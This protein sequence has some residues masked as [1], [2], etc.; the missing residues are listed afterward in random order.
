MLGNIATYPVV[1][2]VHKN[3][4]CHTV[5]LDKDASGREAA[6]ALGRATIA[7]YDGAGVF[8]VEMFETFEGQFLVNE[9][10]PRVH[11]SGHWTDLGAETSQFE[12]HI[13]AITGDKLGSTRAK[14]CATMINILRTSD[15]IFRD[16]M[17]STQTLEN[18]LGHVRWYGKAPKPNTDRKIGHITAIDDDFL[19]AQERALELESTYVA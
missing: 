19:V 8:A 16:Y 7:T 2:T 17:R 14:A 3:N 4:I 5:L 11:N 12:Q 15:G 9:V 18:G 6:E 10:A 13:R 1:E